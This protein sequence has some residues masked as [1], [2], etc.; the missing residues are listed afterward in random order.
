[1]KK[2][3]REAFRVHFKWTVLEYAAVCRTVIQACREFN[4]PRSTFY[5]WK[6]AYE[7]GG[8]AGLAREKPVVLNHPRK[9]A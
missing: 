4:V 6:K 9:L 7:K 2:G 5:E 3:V 8:K 1:M